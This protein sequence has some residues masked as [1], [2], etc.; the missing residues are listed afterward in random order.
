MALLR[1]EE[2]LWLRDLYGVMSR[3]P[4]ASFAYTTNDDGVWLTFGKGRDDR[5]NLG[6]SHD[7][8]RTALFEYLQK[9]ETKR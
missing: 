3:N 9:S 8:A 2:L 5:I 6:W 4:D 1:E 7:S